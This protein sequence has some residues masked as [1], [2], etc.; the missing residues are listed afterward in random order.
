MADV[1]YIITVANITNKTDAVTSAAVAAVDI[2]PVTEERARDFTIC[3]DTTVIDSPGVIKRTIIAELSTEFESK[4]LTNDD[5]LSALR[6]A[7]QRRFER[8]LP[9]AGGLVTEEVEIGAFCP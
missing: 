3:D 9:A 2:D 5:Q 7:F 8:I 1:R 4:F 6:K